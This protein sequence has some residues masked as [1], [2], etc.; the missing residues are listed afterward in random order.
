MWGT[1][2]IKEVRLQEHEA[3][4][5]LSQSKKLDLSQKLFMG[6]KFKYWKQR[7]FS[8]LLKIVSPSYFC[9]LIMANKELI[10][11]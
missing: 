6:S 3:I 8:C 11:D 4:L 5:D 7:E 1:L 9:Y 10:N 2:H